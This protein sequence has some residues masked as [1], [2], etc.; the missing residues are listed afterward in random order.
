MLTEAAHNVRWALRSLKH[1]RGF[2]AAAILTIALGVGSNTSVFSVIRAVLLRPC[3]F[4][5]LSGW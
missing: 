2:A 1:S 3:R 4:A 5:I